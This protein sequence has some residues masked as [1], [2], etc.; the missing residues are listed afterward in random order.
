MLIRKEIAL[1]LVSDQF[2][3]LS[4]IITELVRRQIGKCLAKTD[5]IE[6]CYE[7]GGKSFYWITQRHKNRNGKR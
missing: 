5:E 2:F 7:K 6:I 1:T 4:D 3:F